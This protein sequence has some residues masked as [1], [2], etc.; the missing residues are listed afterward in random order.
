MLVDAVSVAHALYDFEAGRGTGRAS[1]T[2]NQLR[3]EAIQI[4]LQFSPHPANINAWSFGLV[5]V[6]VCRI[7]RAGDLVRL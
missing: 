1:A 3:V 7:A 2:V 5:V 4:D 6:T